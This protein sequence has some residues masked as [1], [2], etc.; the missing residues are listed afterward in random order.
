MYLA[1]S[2][3]M[4]FT[5]NNEF[6]DLTKTIQNSFDTLEYFSNKK[7]IY[8]KLIMKNEIIEIF[9]NFYGDK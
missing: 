2:N 8:P 3:N 1:K 4:N 5:I 6:F 7:K 9:K